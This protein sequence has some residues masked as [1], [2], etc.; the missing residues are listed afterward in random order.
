MLR[1]LRTWMNNSLHERLIANT[2]AMDYENCVVM[3][4][5]TLEG[6]IWAGEG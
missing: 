5:Y 6:T 4:L 2:A 3:S 1:A